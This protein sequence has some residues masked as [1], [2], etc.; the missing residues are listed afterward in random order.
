MKGSQ[1]MKLYLNKLI[2]VVLISLPIL[3]TA[4]ML[5]TVADNVIF[6]EDSTGHSKVFVIDSLS[7]RHEVSEVKYLSEQHHEKTDVSVQST[8]IL[9]FLGLL[10]FVGLSN[11][12][13][14]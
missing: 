6:K 12:S 2:F 3:A 8:L 9:L 7:T 4:Q 5:N 13:N 14:V 10:G 1:T 11:R